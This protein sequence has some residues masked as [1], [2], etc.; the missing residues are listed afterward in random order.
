MGDGAIGERIRLIRGRLQ[1]RLLLPQLH[2][3]MREQAPLVR[4]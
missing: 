1:V 4:G 3:R 2:T